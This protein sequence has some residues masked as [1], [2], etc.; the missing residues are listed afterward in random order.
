VLHGACSS[1]HAVIPAYCYYNNT[2]NADSIKKFGALYN[3]YTVYTGKLAPAGWHVPTDSEWE[4]MQSYLVM[5]GYNYDGTTDTT[6]NKI[7]MALAA[8][9]D[10]YS[11][12]STGTIGNELDKE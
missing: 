9:T 3:W 12:T 11:D 5:H 8:K 10:W 1:S 6:N 4:V 7:A 2:T